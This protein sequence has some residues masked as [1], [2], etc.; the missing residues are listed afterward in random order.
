MGEAPLCIQ[1]NPQRESTAL[2]PFLRKIIITRMC[3][4]PRLRDY[5]G[6]KQHTIIG[7]SDNQISNQL[8]EIRDMHGRISHQDPH[9]QPLQHS[10]HHHQVATI[11]GQPPDTTNRSHQCPTAPSPPPPPADEVPPRE[12]A[13]S[14]RILDPLMFDRTRTTL[15]HFTIKLKA[16]LCTN[17]YLVPFRMSHRRPRGQLPGR[18]I[19]RL[20][21]VLLR[22]GHIASHHYDHGRAFHQLKEAFPYQDPINTAHCELEVL[23]QGNRD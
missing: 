3:N 23:R 14:R 17:A 6:D 5:K 7:N 4:K 22:R 8:A 18:K 9:H 10:S 16:K 1:Q 12:G 2:N 13:R 20:H 15:T 11:Q 19:P 21:H